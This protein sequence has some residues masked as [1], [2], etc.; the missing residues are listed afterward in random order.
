MSPIR[1]DRRGPIH[2]LNNHAGSS[3]PQS[4]LPLHP[5][6]PAPQLSPPRL[7]HV[8]HKPS[9]HFTRTPLEEGHPFVARQRPQPSCQLVQARFRHTTRF[10]G[11]PHH[12]AVKLQRLL[13]P[14]RN[15]R[16]RH[17][18]PYPP[19]LPR[20]L[21][22]SA[23][24]VPFIK[25]GTGS[26]NRF[27]ETAQPLWALALDIRTASRPMCWNGKQHVFIDRCSGRVEAGYQP[28]RV[29]GT[30]ATVH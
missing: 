15:T 5:P 30:A 16:F 1:N 24:S 25:K 27:N 17:H 2:L 11:L 10:P 19:L 6:E 26:D 21:Q 9:L 7:H 20:A 22:H 29:K 8:H 3:I 23:A 12:H 14:R 28:C 18:T 4:A 13:P